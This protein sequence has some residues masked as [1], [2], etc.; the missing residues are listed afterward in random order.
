MLGAFQLAMHLVCGLVGGRCFLQTPQSQHH[1]SQ[2]SWAAR[3]ITGLLI[4]V[5]PK[6]VVFSFSFL[7][8]LN[9]VK[10]Q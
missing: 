1:V 5:P 8:Y 9:S 7:V 10:Q 3:Y 2:K 6:G 4:Q